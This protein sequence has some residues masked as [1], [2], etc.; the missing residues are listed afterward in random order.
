[1]NSINPDQAQNEITRMRKTIVLLSITLI[2]S[3]IV[4][5]VLLKAILN[6]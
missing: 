5:S 2:V 4:F 3:L 6:T 1:M